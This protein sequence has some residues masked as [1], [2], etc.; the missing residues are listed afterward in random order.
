MQCWV[1]KFLHTSRDRILFLYENFKADGK[2]LLPSSRIIIE[3]VD[4]FILTTLLRLLFIF[5]FSLFETWIYNIYFM[6]FHIGKSA[7][8]TSRLSNNSEGE[9][10]WFLVY[11]TRVWILRILQSSIS[12]QENLWICHISSLFQ[13]NFSAHHTC[14]CK[15]THTHANISHANISTY[16]K[17]DKINNK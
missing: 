1:L 11:N 10:E 2:F 9:L 13:I 7:D 3:C 15:R 4:L 17:D 16:K 5:S 8:R 6:Y 14:T 12:F